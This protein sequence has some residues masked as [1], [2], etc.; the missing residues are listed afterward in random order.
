MGGGG[1]LAVPTANQGLQGTVQL[2]T[3]VGRFL[4]AHVDRT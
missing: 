4:D 3:Y 2:G 1:P